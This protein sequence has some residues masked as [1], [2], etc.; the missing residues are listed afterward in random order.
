MAN[1]LKYSWMHLRVSLSC[2]EISKSGSSF[3]FCTGLFL[4]L[5]S[6]PPFSLSSTFHE[7]VSVQLKE[8]RMSKQR[9]CG[10][11]G[12]RER[13]VVACDME[14]GGDEGGDR[15]SPLQ[16]LWE[17]PAMRDVRHAARGVTGG[18]WE[19]FW[20]RVALDGVRFCQLDSDF[21]L[22]QIELCSRSF[23]NYAGS[24][25]IKCISIKPKH[26]PSI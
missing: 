18:F 5:S 16:H 26:R 1:A 9:S 17:R 12:G 10:K 8:Y 25:D 20:T 19:S 14:G 4:F 2:W 21:V 3:F 6:L 11:V 24:F 23:V 7:S 22:N 13:R 15:C